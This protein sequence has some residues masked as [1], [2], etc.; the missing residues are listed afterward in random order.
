[1]AEPMNAGDQFASLKVEEEGIF[2]AE[3]PAHVTRQ[4]IESMLQEVWQHPGWKQPWG[5]VV[6]VEEGTTYD[7]DVRKTGVPGDEMRAA[8]TAVVTPSLMQ[9]TVVKTMGMGLRLGSNFQLTGHAELSEALDAVRE[10]VRAQ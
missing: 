9:R 6:V 8:A 4:T 2:V 5:L 7:A 3:M 1:M 10:R